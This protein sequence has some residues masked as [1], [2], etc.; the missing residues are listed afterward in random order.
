MI[1]R[2][3][4]A[5]FATVQFP[6]IRLRPETTPLLEEE[7]DALLNALVA[8]L[9]HPFGLHRPEPWAALTTGDYPMDAVKIERANRADQR[10]DR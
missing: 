4:F 3:K 10:F 7:G 8:H 2:R 5:P 1:L 6:A 9:S